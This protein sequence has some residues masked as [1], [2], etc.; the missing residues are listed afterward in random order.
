MSPF[1]KILS[2]L[3][4]GGFVLAIILSIV[5]RRLFSSNKRKS[6]AL[7]SQIIGTVGGARNGRYANSEYERRS[8]SL[9]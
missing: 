2:E 9:K 6:V 1:W 7:A 3:S 5:A 4:V 8:A